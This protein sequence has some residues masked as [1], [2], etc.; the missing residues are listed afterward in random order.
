MIILA[1]IWT[2][3]PAFMQ[4][5]LTTIP[6]EDVPLAHNIYD[7]EDRAIIIYKNQEEHTLQLQN[8]QTGKRYTLSFSGSTIFM[9]KNEQPLSFQQLNCG[10]MVHVLFYKETKTAVKI[11]ELKDCIYLPNV[12]Q[13]KLDMQKKTLKVKDEEYQLNSHITIIGDDKEMELMDINEMDTLSIW[14]YQD[15][16]FSIQ[17]TNGHGYLRLQNNTY[18]VDGWIDIGQKIIKKVTE[19]MLIVVPEGT[20]T[21]TITHNDSSATQ[22]ITFK[23]N[24]EIVWDLSTVEIV[25]PKTGTIIFTISPDNAS[26]VIDGK[27]ADIAN[28]VELTYGVHQISV[29]AENYDTL[30][31]YIKVGAPS[32]NIALNLE[33]NKKITKEETK[34]TKETE[35]ETDH[36]NTDKNNNTTQ[37]STK[38]ETKNE[39]RKETLSET[40]KTGNQTDSVSAADSY[41]VHIDSPEGAEVYIDGNYIGISPVSFDKKSGNYI[42]TLRKNGCQTRSYTLQ[43]DSSEKDVNYSFSELLPRN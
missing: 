26:V 40:E 17:V 24:E 2:F 13:F 1:A 11:Q 29:S 7:S 5:E 25:Q 35:K 15:Q 38:S 31:K 39:E 22:Q 10:M 42:I 37:S 9:D 34:E 41:Q 3:A 28:P 32:A 43:I 12:S 4:E 18:F 16:I 30:S 36:E 19:D 8:L 23:K 21:A 14:G 6:V 27:K 20:F 33:Q